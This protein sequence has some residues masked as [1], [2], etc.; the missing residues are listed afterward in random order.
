MYTGK[1]QLLKA[2]ACCCA[3]CT[4]TAW[5]VRNMH[6]CVC[7]AAPCVAVNVA[8]PVAMRP[9]AYANS[10]R[11]TKVCTSQSSSMLLLISTQHTAV[12]TLRST[13]PTG[14]CSYICMLARVCNTAVL[15]IWATEDTDL[16]LPGAYLLPQWWSP[17]QLCHNTSHK[18]KRKL[19]SYNGTDPEC[20]IRI[21][22]RHMCRL[23]AL[24]IA[25]HS[26]STPSAS[27]ELCAFLHL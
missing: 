4:C 21:P 1:H 14:Q 7:R 13:Y 12:Q 3:S 26:A 9:H 6:Y 18:N 25:V 17:A 24:A 27:A 8:P 11:A 10:W 19:R 16:G 5:Y 22:Y 23:R 2:S 15:Q 20:G